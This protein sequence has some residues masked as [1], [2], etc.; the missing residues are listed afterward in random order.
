LQCKLLFLRWSYWHASRGKARAKIAGVYRLTSVS[1][2][3]DEYE[4]QVLKCNANNRIKTCSGELDGSIKAPSA[5]LHIFS[6]R[7]LYLC[8]CTRL[9]KVL[10]WSTRV[11][12]VKKHTLRQLKHCFTVNA[13]YACRLFW[14]WRRV[15]ANAGSDLPVHSALTDTGQTR[16][17]LCRVIPK[18]SLPDEIWNCIAMKM[19]EFR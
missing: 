10:E 8:I 13:E 2:E 4:A 18:V 19:Q 16:R 7:H 14:R 12:A 17:L 1:I 3:T 11:S 5:A 15:S 9:F 6:N